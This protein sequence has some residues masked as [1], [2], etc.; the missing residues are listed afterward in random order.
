MN[1]WR[2]FIYKVL[3]GWKTYLKKDE[4]KLPHE[5]F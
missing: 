1:N 4:G 5:N 2:E 3:L